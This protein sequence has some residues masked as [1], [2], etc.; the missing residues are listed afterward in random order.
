ML[1]ESPNCPNH[2]IESTDVAFPK[3]VGESKS[4]WLLAY[5]F[6]FIA[7]NEQIPKSAQKL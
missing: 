2:G 1:A 5:N 6:I 3:P 7:I 4:Q